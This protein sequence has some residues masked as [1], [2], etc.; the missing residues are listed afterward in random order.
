MP[1]AGSVKGRNPHQAVDAGL[2]FQI[3]VSVE[4]LNKN[5]GAFQPRFFAIQVVQGFHL[6]I[7]ALAPAAVHSVKH[8]RPVLSLSAAGAGVEGQNR[9]ISVILSCEQ[10][11]QA[12]LL[13][14]FSDLFHLLLGI[15]QNRKILLFIT[16]LDEGQGILIAGHQSLIGGNLVF[17]H[18]GSLNDLLRFFHI[19]PKIRRRLSLL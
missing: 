10:G 17:Q 14:L 18:T 15:R 11:S 5:H 6:E 8:L 1:A 4:A 19:I 2:A 7:V 9:V 12:L 13:Q 3:A 16:H